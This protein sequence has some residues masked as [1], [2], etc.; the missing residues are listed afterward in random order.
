[1]IIQN[2]SVISAQPF[3]FVDENGMPVNGIGL[4]YLDTT[5]PFPIKENLK[6]QKISVMD[7]DLRA[8]I[9]FIKEF[10][11]IVELHQIPDGNKLRLESIE[12]K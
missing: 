3:D 2:V 1:M 4:W 11:T 9:S 6:P 12:F 8:K 5:K 10:P 7:A